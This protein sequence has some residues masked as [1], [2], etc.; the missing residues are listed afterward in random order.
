MNI[1]LPRG[2]RETFLPRDFHTLPRAAKRTNSPCCDATKTTED[3]Y[4]RELMLHLWIYSNI[5][6]Y[7]Y[8]RTYIHSA[9]Y[10]MFVL[11]RSVEP[12]QLCCSFCSCCYSTGFSRHLQVQSLVLSKSIQ[13]IS[14][15][16][17]QDSPSMFSSTFSGAASA[18]TICKQKSAIR[19]ALLYAALSQGEAIQKTS[20]VSNVSSIRIHWLY[21]DISGALLFLCSKIKAWNPTEYVPHATEELVHD[22]DPASSA[23]DFRP[24]WPGQRR[25]TSV[26]IKWRSPD[27]LAMIPP[28]TPHTHSNKKEKK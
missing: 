12:V 14:Q 21:P 19:S 24:G 18:W 13:V 22:F 9:L 15:C 8:I 26:S 7:I 4:T 10:N 25:A 3:S 17:Q 16:I 6:K 28:Q 1:E 5:Y 11:A 2:F 23:L 20:S 27:P